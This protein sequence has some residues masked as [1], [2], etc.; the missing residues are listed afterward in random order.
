MCVQNRDG[1]SSSSEVKCVFETE[2]FKE[3]IKDLKAADPGDMQGKETEKDRERE[4][5]V[6]QL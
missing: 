4:R 1:P 3:F 5:T 2:P 6:T